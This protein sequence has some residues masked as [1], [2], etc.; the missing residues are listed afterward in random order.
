MYH[1]F[2]GNGGPSLLLTSERSIL[3]H[4]AGSF[5]IWS[6][7]LSCACRSGSTEQQVAPGSRC[8]WARHPSS[9]GEGVRGARS[10]GGHTHGAAAPAGACC[11]GCSRLAWQGITAS[12]AARAAGPARGQRTEAQQHCRPA[13]QASTAAD[14]GGVLKHRFGQLS[15][16]PAQCSTNCCTGGQLQGARQSDPGEGAGLH[17]KVSTRTQTQLPSSARFA[18][19]L[20]VLTF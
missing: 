1:E 3:I 2:A 7:S 16:T 9:R 4:F 5:W 17:G 20:A 14:Q 8:P 15:F 13:L 10:G 11:G 6:L 19:M 18:C 12:A